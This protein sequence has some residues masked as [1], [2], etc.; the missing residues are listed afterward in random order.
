MN[1]FYD[2]EVIR[3]KQIIEAA[4]TEIGKAGC[5]NIT[6]SH[7]ASAS[8]LSKGGLSHYYKSKEELFKA[9]FEEFFERVFLR[10][11][12]NMALY[13]DPL[14]KLLSYDILYDRNDPLMIGYPILFDFMSIAV[15]NNVYRK[16]FH[17]W[18]DKWI[19]L[20]IEPLKTGLK[21]KIFRNINPEKT[22]RLISSIYQGI[23]ERWFLAPDKHTQEWAVSSY[24]IAITNLLK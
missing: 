19:E 1:R 23:A 8:G 21:Q 10:S 11:K 13:N 17:K 15:H 24:K 2:L 12:E 5:N 7:I 6:M 4:L 16:I 20:L 22:A 14:D 18:V 3:K 9:V